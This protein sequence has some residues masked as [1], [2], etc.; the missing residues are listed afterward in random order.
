MTEGTPRPLFTFLRYIETTM[1]ETP[2][3]IAQHVAIIGAGVAGLTCAYRLTQHHPDWQVTVL[4]Q[5]PFAGGNVRAIT[6]E[7][8]TF[9]L[10]ANG[11]L[12]AP[13]TLTLFDDLG[14]SPEPAADSAKRRFIFKN[15][16]LHAL[17]ESPV[18]LL[19]F[20]L[21]LPSEKVRVLLEPWLTKQHPQ[22]ESVHGFIARHFGNTF[23]DVFAEPLVLGVSGGNA[24]KTSLDAL[25]PRMR[26]LEW[27]H[28]SLLKGMIHMQRV[29]KKRAQETGQTPPKRRLMSLAG[30]M[31]TLTA[32]LAQ[33]L[34]PHIRCN[35]S[36]IDI[37]QQDGG[38]RLQLQHGEV[39]DAHQVVVTAPAHT[40]ASLVQNISA[41]SASTLRE[42][43]FVDMRVLALGFNRVDV[44]HALDGFGFLVPAGQ[45]VESLG[46]LFTSSLFRDRA[47][48]GKI[49]VRVITGGHRQ[50]DICERPFDE[51]LASVR[52]DLER[53]LGISAA[54][55]MVYDIPWR[56]GIPQY[57]LG[58]RERVAR[59]E[60]ALPE[61]VWLAGNS[62]HGIGVNDT[63]E[64]AHTLVQRL[65]HHHQSPI[66]A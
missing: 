3:H 7:G 28:Q 35:T 54:P 61:G 42:I 60:Q 16:G 2:Q 66:P 53:T 10:A 65:A 22:E 26:Q 40:A 45:S 44:P 17:P 59:A 37:Q 62:Y 34:E 13:D 9:D 29:A 38:F 46:V 48:A 51:V 33:Q 21:L 39:L 63:I 56:C 30:G 36:V 12:P 64:H 5:S 11:V 6:H 20:P 25:F 18:G 27:Q 41:E 19:R 57:L 58:H 15:G 31:G 32:T 43:P 1:T 4:E 47:P 8:Y 52:R 55:D 23:A 50:P 14:L 24:K 49:L